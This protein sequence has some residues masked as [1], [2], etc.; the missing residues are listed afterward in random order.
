MLHHLDHGHGPPVVLLHAG[1]L[2]HRLWTPQVA[3]LARSRRVVAL[4]L[5][6]HGWSPTPDVPFR[7]VDDVV[8]LLRALDTGPATLVGISLGARTAVDVALEAPELV[9][10]L[11]VSG[12][13]AG[14]PDFRDPGIL[15]LFTRW[16]R[17]EQERDPD[18]WVEIFLRLGF[19]PDRALADIDPAVVDPV[20]EMARTTLRRHV[21]DGPP[22]PPTPVADAREQASALAV[23]VLAVV[24]ELDWPD[25]RRLARELAAEAPDGGVVAIPGAAH[26]P[27]LEQPEA[28]I[29]LLREQ[30]AA[31]IG[32]PTAHVRETRRIQSRPRI[33]RTTGTKP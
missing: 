20:R 29:A 10:R 13:G 3:E 30:L 19:G 22:V 5:R 12:A 33:G 25:H 1:A 23:P 27:N 4:D 15:D 11:V 32:A 21:P 7:H 14:E 17:A 18:A 8:A 2:D 31:L 9:D 28:F 16:A 26:Y 6:G 24:G